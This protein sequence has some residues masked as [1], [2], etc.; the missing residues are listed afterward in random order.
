MADSCSCW[1]GPNPCD[2][3]CKRCRERINEDNGKTEA[4]KL[5]C[6]RCKKKV[7]R[8]YGADL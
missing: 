1:G 6:K 4:M 5:L 3:A 7:L 2:F 8:E